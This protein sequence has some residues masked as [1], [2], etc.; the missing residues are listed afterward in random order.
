[1]MDCCIFSSSRESVVLR[2]SLKSES[3]DLLS[4]PEKLSHFVLASLLAKSCAML[5]KLH[6]T[7]I[8]ITRISYFFSPLAI[9]DSM[10]FAQ[11]GI[12]SVFIP[13][14]LSDSLIF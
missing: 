14:N 3:R 8:P 9:I 13:S 7:D 5:D 12:N 1:M 11:N 6:S 10:S 4:M 2:N